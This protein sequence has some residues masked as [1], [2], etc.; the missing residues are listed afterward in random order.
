MKFRIFIIKHKLN[1][2]SLLKR[3][4]IHLISLENNKPHQHLDKNEACLLE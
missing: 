3:G 2:H 4:G 1:Q